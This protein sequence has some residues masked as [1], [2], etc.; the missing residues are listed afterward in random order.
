MPCTEQKPLHQVF[1]TLAQEIVSRSTF[2]VICKAGLPQWPD[3]WSKAAL[4]PHL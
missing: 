2:I 4:S 3:K 1:L